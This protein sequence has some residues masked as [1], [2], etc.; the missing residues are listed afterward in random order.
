VVHGKVGGD[1]GKGRE[2]DQNRR[3]KSKKTREKSNN[4]QRRQREAP[5]QGTLVFSTPF[6]DWRGCLHGANKNKGSGSGN[7]GRGS[8]SCAETLPGKVIGLGQDK[9][10]A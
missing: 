6:K 8:K 4:D 2:Q 1:G 5:S 7:D 3:L 9:H 10:V